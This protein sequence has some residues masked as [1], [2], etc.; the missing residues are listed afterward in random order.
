MKHLFVPI[1]SLLILF[2]CI[3]EKNNNYF[4]GDI[5]IKLIDVN[6]ALYG[7][8]EDQIE[9][10]KKN[11]S[12][13]DDN[14]HSISEK[15]FLEYHNILIQ[16]DLY[17]NPC[18]KLKTDSGKIIN[19]YTNESEYLKLKKELKDFDRDSEK[20]RLKFEGSKISDGVIDPD[21]VFDKAIYKANQIIFIKKTKGKTEWAK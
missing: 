15:R 2:S 21:G 19:V 16:K 13:I 18:F 6:N 5:Y 1:F 8:T 3:E 7:L 10:F 17:K 14:E 12:N 11:I 9:K 4:Q 20:I